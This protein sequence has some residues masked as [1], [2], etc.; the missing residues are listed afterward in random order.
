MSLK[1]LLLVS[2]HK[3]FMHVCV[4]LSRSGPGD[5]AF[6]VAGPYKESWAQLGKLRLQLGAALHLIPQ[7]ALELLWVTD[8]PLLEYDEGRWTSVH[9]PFTSPQ[10]G[11]KQDPAQIKA[12]AYDIVFNGVELGGGSIRIHNPEIQ[13]KIFD[14][15]GL[16]RE[17]MEAHFGFLLEAQELGFPPHGGIALG[18]DRFVMLLLHCASI[19]DVIAFPKTQSGADPM[20]QA[21]TP[22]DEKK[23]A[24]YGIKVVVEKA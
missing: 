4:L 13:R 12:R 3:I 16:K 1:L 6:L 7:D 8:L 24:E 17:E 21:P 23:L 14:F 9:H 19:R 10:P 15:L 22:V 2:C 5:T 18:I 11:W 20:M